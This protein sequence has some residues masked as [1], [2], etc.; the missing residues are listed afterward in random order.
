MR[1]VIFMYLLTSS[2][3]NHLK[4]PRLSIDLDPYQEEICHLYRT[5]VSRKDI[6]KLLYPVS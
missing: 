1:Y 3:Y 2:L 4:V 5:D 6:A